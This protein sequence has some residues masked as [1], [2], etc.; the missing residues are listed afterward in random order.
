MVSDQ[1]TTPATRSAAA[2]I[3]AIVVDADPLNGMSAL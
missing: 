3:A 2:K 1:A